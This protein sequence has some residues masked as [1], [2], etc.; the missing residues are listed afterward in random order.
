MRRF[1]RAPGARFAPDACPRMEHLRLLRRSLTTDEYRALRRLTGGMR[2]LPF[3]GDPD[4]E[5]HVL[6]AATDEDLEL[7]AK[8][9]AALQERGIG[10][11]RVE[12]GDPEGDAAE[13][14]GVGPV[15]AARLQFHFDEDS[16]ELAAFLGSLRR[17][18]FRAVSIDTGIEVTVFVDLD[19]QSDLE[20]VQSMR[21]AQSL[22]EIV[23]RTA[24]HA[25]K[26]HRVGR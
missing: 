24:A 3:D 5:A 2:H 6:L 13:G 10:G 20:V 1:V 8:C 14:A 19:G 12:D 7:L 4:A 15:R 22:R 18:G 17:N 16:G 26:G 21:L 11:G 23:R 9:Q 25:L